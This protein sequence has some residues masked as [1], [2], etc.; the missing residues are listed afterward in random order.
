MMIDCREAAVLSS[1]ELDRRLRR[2]ERFS[3]WLHRL[4][5]PACRLYKRQLE[6]MRRV[7]RR[8]GEAPA[9]S[10]VASPPARLD[11]AARARLRERL[12]AAAQGHG[13]RDP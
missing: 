6:A 5:C 13:E 7:A 1:A 11:D 12:R 8:F 4:V 3:L 2:G 9:D 10:G